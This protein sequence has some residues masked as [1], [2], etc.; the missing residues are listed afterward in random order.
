MVLAPC[1]NDVKYSSKGNSV[2]VSKDLE[3]IAVT[4]FCFQW[5]KDFVAPPDMLHGTLIFCSIC[6]L[7]TMLTESHD[8]RKFFQHILTH[9]F[10]VFSPI[11]C[12]S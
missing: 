9:H 6:G 3:G 4:A 7:V 8:G 1:A 5:K 12:S 10:I 2:P 11:F